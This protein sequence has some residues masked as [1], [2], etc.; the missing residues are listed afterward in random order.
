MIT[1]LLI[2]KQFIRV[3]HPPFYEFTDKFSLS[4]PKRTREFALKLQRFL[5][6]QER[7]RGK[8]I[9]KLG[10]DDV[11]DRYC[12]LT[13]RELNHYS[14]FRNTGEFLS[15]TTIKEEKDINAD[16]GDSTSKVTIFMKNIVRKIVGKF[17]TALT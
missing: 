11:R 7:G 1:S 17:S 8:E 10:G 3:C 12:L 2:T 13:S 16:N 5:Q 15:R 9:N 6:G 4:T 14:C